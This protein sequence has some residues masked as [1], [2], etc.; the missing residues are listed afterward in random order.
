MS[1]GGELQTRVAGVDGRTCG[2]LIERDL[3]KSWHRLWRHVPDGVKHVGRVQAIMIYDNAQN[4]TASV[5]S[6]SLKIL[7]NFRRIFFVKK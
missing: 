2:C 1:G 6:L 5:L 4:S 7:R 3:W